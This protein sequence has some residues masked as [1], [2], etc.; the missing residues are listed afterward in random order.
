MGVTCGGLNI[1][2]YM[3]V[4]WLVEDQEEERVPDIDYPIMTGHDPY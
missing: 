3:V 2:T 1:I 4:W